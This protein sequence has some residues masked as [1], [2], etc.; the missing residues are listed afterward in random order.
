MPFQ[1][2]YFFYDVS[3]Y[4]SNNPQ[5]TFS[6]FYSVTI[7]SQLFLEY[8]YYYSVYQGFLIVDLFWN[9]EFLWFMK[10][11]NV[12]AIPMIFDYH[13]HLYFITLKSFEFVQNMYTWVP[14]RIF[15]NNKAE[16]LFL[17][18]RSSLVVNFLAYIFQT[19]LS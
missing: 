13:W 12:Y 3:T 6:M 7:E 8:V 10:P 14:S 15:P 2:H 9:L 5:V 17:P 1:I 18:L 11:I 19:I 4:L 16:G